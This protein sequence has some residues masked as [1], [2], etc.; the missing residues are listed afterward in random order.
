MGITGQ[1]EERYNVGRPG[2]TLKAYLPSPYTY[3]VN[4]SFCLHSHTAQVDSA[5]FSFGKFKIQLFFFGSYLRFLADVQFICS[6]YFNFEYA[7]T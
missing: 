4:G 3:S 5:A 7:N 6:I 2:G 1:R